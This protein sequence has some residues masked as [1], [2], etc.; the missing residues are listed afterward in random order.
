MRTCVC[1]TRCACADFWL[2]RPASVAGT[3]CRSDHVSGHCCRGQPGSGVFDLLPWRRGRWEQAGLSPGMASAVV[4]AGGRSGR[5]G[6]RRESGCWDSAGSWVPLFLAPSLMSEMAG[7]ISTIHW[8]RC[9]PWMA[10]F[11]R[12]CGARIGKSSRGQVL[13]T[14]STTCCPSTCADMLSGIKEAA[15]PFLESIILNVR[16]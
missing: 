14:R 8:G 13:L 9:P 15:T 10:S 11:T 7:Y 4:S 5:A 3:R 2:R 16:T 6:S 1:G 12:P